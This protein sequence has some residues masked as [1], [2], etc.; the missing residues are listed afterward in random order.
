MTF[1]PR[2]IFITLDDPEEAEHFL[3]G[4]IIARQNNSCE[5]FSN[6]IDATNMVMEP[7][8]MALIE[9]EKSG[10]RSKPR[11]VGVEDA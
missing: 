7:Y 1:K 8:R 3:R 10:V 5:L 11:R 6:L 9:E 2:K 4:L